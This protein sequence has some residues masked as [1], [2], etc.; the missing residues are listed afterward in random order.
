[1]EYGRLYIV[2]PNVHSNDNGDGTGGHS[3]QVDKEAADV[4]KV[5]NELMTYDILPE[6]FGGDTQVRAKGTPKALHTRTINTH[7][8]T[9]PF[10]PPLTP[11]P[12]SIFS[13]P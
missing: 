7:L 9:S 12:P 1:M 4:Q 8:V 10:P 13:Y 6:E 2:T 11:S 5:Q 3:V